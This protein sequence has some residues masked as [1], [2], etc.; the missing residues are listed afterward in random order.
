[1]HRSRMMKK[2]G[3]SSVVQLVRLIDTASPG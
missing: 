1:V 3:V 2:L